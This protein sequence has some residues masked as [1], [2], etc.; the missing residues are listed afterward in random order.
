MF[1]ATRRELEQRKAVLQQEIRQ[2]CRNGSFMPGEPL[3]PVTHFVQQYHLSVAVIRQA[4]QPLMAEGILYTIPRVGTFVGRPPS[5]L[6]EFYLLIVPQQASPG[7]YIAQIQAGFED[8]IARMGGA[9]LVMLRDQAQ[10]CWK[11]RD[12]PRL[13]GLFDFARV[14]DGEPTW[15]YE[16][17]TPFVQFAD[18]EKDKAACDTVS[19]DDVEGGRQAT[20]H[21]LS[22]GHRHIAYLGLHGAGT[23][24]FFNWSLERAQ[25]WEQEMRRAQCSPEN[26]LFHPQVEPDPGGQQRTARGVARALFRHPE[27]TAIV[28]ANDA[29]AL[30]LFDALHTA[31]I[32]PER[33]PA[34]VSFDDELSKAGYIVT[35]LRLPWEEIGDAAAALLWERRQGRLTGSPSHRKVS[36]RLIPRLTSRANWSLMAGEGM[37]ASLE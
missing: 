11:K 4:L 17:A 1:M 35:S 21:L 12:F 34:V 20:Q 31:N 19:F 5:L 29:T 23:P 28:T 18:A 37:L 15:A 9:S 7:E 3:P 32:P 13:A 36:M 14:F 2:A 6:S 8:R 25:G 22:L 24:Q 33:W 10:D 27:V 26:W 30:G 16:R